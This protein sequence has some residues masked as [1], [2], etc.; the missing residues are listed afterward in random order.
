MFDIPS[1]S[2][3]DLFVLP[4]YNFYT[5]FFFFV[6]PFSWKGLPSFDDSRWSARNRRANR[7]LPLLC[8]LCIMSLRLNNLGLHSYCLVCQSLAPVWLVQ[9]HVR[10]CLGP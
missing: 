4:F 1:V 8:V 7:S 3:F 5:F 9:I 6:L 10:S 2:L